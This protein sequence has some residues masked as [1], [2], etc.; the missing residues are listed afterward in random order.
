MSNLEGGLGVK[1]LA[2]QNH[3]LLLKIAYKLQGHSD[4]T[5]RTWLLDDMNYDIGDGLPDNSF[6]KRLLSTEQQRYRALTR[7][8]VRD[9]CA[10]SFWFDYWLPLS[11]LC[12]QFLALIS[13]VTRPHYFVASTMSSSLNLRLRPRLSTAVRMSFVP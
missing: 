5:W 6:L 7:V 2:T 13:H 3:Y 9:G 4:A 10:T 1:D 11:P 8:N 12:L